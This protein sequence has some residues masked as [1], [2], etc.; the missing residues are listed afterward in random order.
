MLIVMLGLQIKD[1]VDSL[2]FIIELK[3][4]LW[5][6]LSIKSRINTS[7]YD[8]GIHNYNSLTPFSAYGLKESL[9]NFNVHKQD[10]D[11][12]E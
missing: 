2:K 9:C 12:Y 10:W 8:P 6:Q 7:A 1:L 11:K 5:T 3:Y 4:Y